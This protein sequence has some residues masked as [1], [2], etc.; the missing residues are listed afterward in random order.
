MIPSLQLT[1]EIR[2]EATKGFLYTMWTQM[3]TSKQRKA[4]WRDNNLQR[5]HETNPSK[6]HKSPPH[7]RLE[8]KQSHLVILELWVICYGLLCWIRLIL[9]S[10]WSQ[11]VDLFSIRAALIILAAISNLQIS[12]QLEPGHIIPP[13]TWLFMIFRTAHHIVEH[14]LW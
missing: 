3:K 12:E 5:Q 7:T 8:E 11:S 4:F 14:N 2:S 13:D 6:R 1:E 10:D 9:K